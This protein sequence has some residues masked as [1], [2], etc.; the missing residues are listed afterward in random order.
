MTTRCINCPLRLLPV[1]E[2]LEDREIDFMQRFKAGEMEVETG[3]TLMMEGSSSP[4]LY[5]VLE[6]MGLRY[7]TLENGQRT[8][9]NFVFPGDFIG[10]QAGVMNEMQHSVEATTDMKLCVFNR[11]MLWTMFRDLPERA[12]DLTWL[13]AV[14][15]HILGESL[16]IIGHLDGQARIARAFVR[17]H[18]RGAA[19]GM[20]ENAKMPLPFRQQDLADSLGLSL[21]HTNK[22]LKLLREDGIATWRDG[23]LNILDYK[24]LCDIAHLDTEREPMLR[25][26]I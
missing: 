14:E 19:L 1:F 3:T 8:V 20:I 23:A 10:L 4:Q 17:L 2:P 12:F 13:A 5:T 15:E 26:L 21:V 7:K 25:P 22:T 18:D 11:K 6:G 9:I 24:R 16:A